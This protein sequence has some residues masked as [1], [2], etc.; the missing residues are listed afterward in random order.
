VSPIENVARLFGRSPVDAT[1]W[2]FPTRLTLDVDGA[3]NLGRNAVTKLLGLRPWHKRTIPVPLYALQTDLTGGRVLRGARRLV[4]SS[5][6]PAKRSRFVDASNEN[7]HL[8]PLTAAPA[9]SRFLRTV[10]PWLKR[11]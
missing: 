3:S 1:E 9:R 2:Y 8:D 4:V 7:S 6:I 5:R 10:I 11:R